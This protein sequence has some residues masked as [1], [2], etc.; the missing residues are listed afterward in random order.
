MAGRAP[1]KTHGGAHQHKLR[2]RKGNARQ[3]QYSLDQHIRIL[4]IRITL[5]PIYRPFAE[6]ELRLSRSGEK[7]RT[8]HDQHTERRAAERS[9]G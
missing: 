8:I 4:A 7:T 1:G 5:R 6:I 9:Q 3:K 2:C